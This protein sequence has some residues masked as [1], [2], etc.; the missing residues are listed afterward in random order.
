MNN[1]DKLVSVLTLVMY[2]AFLSGCSEDGSL[3]ADQSN[4]NYVKIISM[5]PALTES[6]LAGS[7]V[8]FEVEVKYSMKEDFGVITLVIQRAESNFMPLANEVE[9]VQSGQGRVMLKASVDI[10][11]TK[12]IQIFT[13]LNPQGVNQTSVVDSRIYKVIQG[14]GPEA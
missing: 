5:K 11:D 9:I 6:L 1:L 2:V 8:D 14:I 3:G 10:P 4:S 13:P 12:A 7:N